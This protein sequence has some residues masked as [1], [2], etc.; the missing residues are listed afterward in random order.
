VTVYWCDVAWVGDGPTDSVRVCV[1]DDGRIDWVAIRAEAHDDDTRLSGLVLPGFANAHSHAF[2]RALRGRTHA[3]GGSFW[4]WR[5]GMY[6]LA[7]RLDPDSYLALARATYAEMALAGI[8]CVGE[9]HYLHH[10]SDGT[11]YDDPNAM[12]HA[13]QQAAWE[14]GVRLTLLDAAYFKGGL[15]PEGHQLLDPV[16]RRFSD[17]NVDTWATRV[18]RLEPTEA[19]RIGLAAHSIRAVEKIDIGRIAALA[20]ERDAVLHI[21]VSEQPAENDVCRGYYL[22]SPTELLEDE[23]ALGQ[24]V[25]AVHAT[26]LSE[27]DIKLLGTSRTN[28]C[29]TPTTERDLADGIGPA[30]DL[31][32]AGAVVTLGSDQHAVIDPFEEARGLELDERLASLQRGR[33]RPE[34]LVRA[35]TADGHRSLGWPDA[36]RIEAGARADLVAVRLD[37]V[38]TAGSVP[39]QVVMAATSSDV[40]DVIVDGQHVVSDGQHRLGDVGQLLRAAIEPLWR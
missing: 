19:V 39:A 26:H 8:T 12:G 13:L 30:T 24:S 36:G 14:A 34:Q 10:G 6:A 28:V 18:S 5:E 2:H 37:S 7:E 32:E 9:F 1:G 35:A 38:R 27:R 4:T 20:R 31:R 33:F 11:P 17:W 23:G 40:R 16:Q 3:D 29:V 21:H 22:C 15:T 25:T